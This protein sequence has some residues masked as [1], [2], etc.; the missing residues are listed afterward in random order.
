MLLCQAVLEYQSSRAS[1]YHHLY[2][3]IKLSHHHIITLQTDIIPEIKEGTAT[4][5]TAFVL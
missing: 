3:I 5:W 1:K 4:V 2:S